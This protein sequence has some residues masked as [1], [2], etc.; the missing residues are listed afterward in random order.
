[1]GK[2]HFHISGRKK[3]ASPE[4]ID[5][6]ALTKAHKILGSTP[7]NIDSLA[8][9]ERASSSAVDIAQVEGA[10]HRPSDDAYLD[11]HVRL[12]LSEGEWDDDAILPAPR[13][14]FERPSGGR[15]HSRL[16]KS[17]SSSAIRSRTVTNSASPF[18]DHY[19]DDSRANSRSSHK[20]KK[21]PAMLDFSNLRPN[22]RLSRSSC[23]SQPD[24][25]GS[26]TF[27]H[28]NIHNSTASRST[29]TLP[30]LSHSGILGKRSSL[31]RRTKESL[32]SL[33]SDASGSTSSG[34]VQRELHPDTGLSTLYNHYEQMSL[35]QVI[36]QG[37]DPEDS[38]A[39]Q[40]LKHAD[41]QDEAEW[42]E[43]QADQDLDWLHKPLRDPVP[44]T[45]TKPPADASSRKIKGKRVSGKNHGKI[46][47]A[48]K[49]PGSPPSRNSE[50][51]DFH[52][53]SVLLLSDSEEE[54]DQEE[55]ESHADAD[56]DGDA[57][58][59]DPNANMILLNRTYDGGARSTKARPVVRRSEESA[60]ESNRKSQDSDRHPRKS[61][62]RRPSDGSGGSYAAMN[63]SDANKFSPVRRQPAYNPRSPSPRESL[64]S[65]DSKA[66][67]MT[68]QFGFGGQE[69]QAMTILPARRPS[70]AELDLEAA[71]TRASDSAAA[72]QESVP[73]SPDQLTPPLS[74]SS[75]DFYLRSARSSV[76]NPDLPNRI[77]AVTREEK[78]L[79]S[80]LRKKNQAMR[81]IARLEAHGHLLGHGYRLQDFG[82]P[83]S[84]EAAG[85]QPSFERGFP[86]PPK[87]HMQAFRHAESAS[88]PDRQRVFTDSNSEPAMSPTHDGRSPRRPSFDGSE[89]TSPRERQGSAMYQDVLVYLDQRK[90]SFGQGE[91]MG[92]IHDLDKLPMMRSIFDPAPVENA[93]DQH[94]G[95]EDAPGLIN[96]A[97]LRGRFHPG[98]IQTEN[99][100]PTSPTRLETLC[101]LE[102]EEVPRR[103][104]SPI[105]PESFPSVPANRIR[106][107]NRARLS[108]VGWSSPTRVK[109]PQW[110]DDD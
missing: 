41:V 15:G 50:G 82:G 87:I 66:S 34:G 4:A 26:T 95:E 54:D 94:P 71:R 90:S 65:S 74:P 75:V 68:C 8:H 17:Q 6:Q 57:E 93:R 24:S 63:G 48:T 83:S 10:R 21:K 1:M 5:S 46:L 62:N 73:R 2:F 11:E 25:A 88:E 84:S 37:R 64:S 58:A 86:A 33:L 106:S 72:R 16:K 42:E 107:R 31:K 92:S 13:H 78:M 35:L 101:E 12:A 3:P 32:R 104:E 100:P 7:I 53:K 81:E 85:D 47:K 14:T 59:A 96:G 20:S 39:Q 30:S 36:K 98:R 27:N 56:A 38:D 105:S 44:T 49:D 55:A 9:L 77:M 97:S 40:Q 91:A 28:S 99:I 29:C 110:G 45:A 23:Q 109:Q 80:A 52:D 69:N 51:T 103:A 22:S 89:A 70:Q 18:H 108:A 76:D 19:A 61:S 67:V 60:R 43:A 102:A 79:I